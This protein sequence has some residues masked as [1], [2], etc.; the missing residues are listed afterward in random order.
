MTDQSLTSVATGAPVDS[1][2]PFVPEVL[3]DPYPTYHRLRADDPVHWSE[4]LR[5]WVLTRYDDIRDVFFHDPRLS[6]DRSKAS[7]YQGERHEMRGLSSDPPDGVV[8]RQL[9]VQGLSPRTAVV[10]APRVEELVDDLLGLM[11]QGVERHLDQIDLTGEVDLVASFAYPLPIR[12]ISELF[13]VPAADRDR[14]Q[15]WSRDLAVSMDRMYSRRQTGVQDLQAY[16]RTLVQQRR[17]H[18]G[19]DLIS[20]LW[21]AEVDGDR[22]T[23]EELV[24]LA[25]AVIFAGHETTVN[26]IGNGVLALLRHPD[27]LDAMRDDG[28]V[29]RTGVEELL[30]YDSPAQLVSRSAVEDVPLDG[31]VI[32]AGDSV[33]AMLGAA[34]RD[35]SMF[36]DPDT[37]DLTRNPNPHIAFG[38]GAH[39]CLGAALSRREAQTA[40]PALLRRFPQLRL[41]A[42]HPP[43]FRPTLVLRGLEELP[44][45]VD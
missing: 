40:I 24:A 38:H 20:Q 30:R 34:N 25:T 33:V 42:D 12:V 43:R 39:F 11:E 8:V 37:L 1:F 44:V 23:E 13:G 29:V 17:T 21:D 6:S 5:S 36:P 26:L 45:V 7:K 2:N 31:K 27:Q 3:D 35:P 14:F 10:M 28:E 16:M 18:P 41:S 19:S 9:L 32:R 22:L 4:K 15:D